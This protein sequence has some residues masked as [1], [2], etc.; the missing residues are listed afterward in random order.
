[1]TVLFV[2]KGRKERKGK[3]AHR[4]QTPD[5]LSSL[6]FASFASFADKNAL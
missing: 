1:M 2:R 6:F 5:L 3:Q 4:W